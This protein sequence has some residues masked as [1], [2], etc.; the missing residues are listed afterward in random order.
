MPTEWI[1]YGVSKMSLREEWLLHERCPQ[2]CLECNSDL[3]QYP[4]Y[5][6]RRMAGETANISPHGL[7]KQPCWVGITISISHIHFRGLKTQAPRGWN[8][9]ASWIWNRSLVRALGYS[10]QSLKE[11][12]TGLQCLNYLGKRQQRKSGDVLA[13]SQEEPLNT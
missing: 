11:T 10:A 12:N 1:D 3:L 4:S 13:T 2:I 7:C 9:E 6:Q 5:M 8:L